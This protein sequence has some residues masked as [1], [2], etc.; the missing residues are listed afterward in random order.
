MKAS[1]GCF[2]HLRPISMA[3]RYIGVPIKMKH[4]LNKHVFCFLRYEISS[5]II[6]IRPFYPSTK[7]RTFFVRLHDSGDFTYQL[8]NTPNQPHRT[9]G[10][11]TRLH[12]FRD[13]TH[14]VINNTRLFY[15]M[16][17]HLRFIIWFSTLPKIF[18]IFFLSCKIFQ[19]CYLVILMLYPESVVDKLV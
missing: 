14:Q 13:F 19:T 11:S 5:N 4:V 16:I 9:G 15:W 3:I 1:C 2:N 17:Y 12:D 6:S 7:S 18:Q 10:K 8:I